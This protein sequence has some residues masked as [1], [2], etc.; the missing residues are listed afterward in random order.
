MSGRVP[1]CGRADSARSNNEAFSQAVRAIEMFDHRLRQIPKKSRH[2]DSFKTNV[3]N[4]VTTPARSV[5]YLNG[6][7]IGASHSLEVNA[8][9][10]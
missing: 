8:R 6:W 5:T 1:N 7:L 3:T 2:T 4:A 10:L 9:L